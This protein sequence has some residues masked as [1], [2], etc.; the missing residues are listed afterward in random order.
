MLLSNVGNHDLMNM[1]SYL[2][3][4]KSLTFSS[5]DKGIGIYVF[6]ESV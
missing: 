3:L 6:P 5:Q 1:R 4:A 2:T